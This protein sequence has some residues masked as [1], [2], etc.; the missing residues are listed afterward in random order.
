[1]KYDKV[2]EKTTK[3]KQSYLHDWGFQATNNKVFKQ[4]N[5]TIV[6]AKTSVGFPRLTQKHMEPSLFVRLR[7]KHRQNKDIDKLPMVS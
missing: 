7:D 3:D 2:Y 5:K 1:M 6:R 4:T